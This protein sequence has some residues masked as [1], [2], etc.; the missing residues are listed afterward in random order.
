VEDMKRKHNIFILEA[1]KVTPFK[2]PDL[3]SSVTPK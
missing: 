1:Q 3:D 2:T